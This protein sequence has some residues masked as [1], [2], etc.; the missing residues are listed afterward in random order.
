MSVGTSTNPSRLRPK[1]VLL[2][3]FSVALIMEFPVVDIPRLPIVK[4]AEAVLGRPASPNSVAGVRRRTRRRTRDRIAAGTR[5][6]SLPAGCS[7]VIR[8]G[9]TYHHCGGAY[10]RPSYEGNNVVYVVVDNP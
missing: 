8:R 5:V 6:Y 2:L 4:D 1:H 7:K 10:Y 3:V 9:M